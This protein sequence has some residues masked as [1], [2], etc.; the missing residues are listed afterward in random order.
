MRTNQ[1][2]VSMLELEYQN[3]RRH[4]QMRLK[5]RK[6]QI[7]ENY[8]Q[9]EKIDDEINL[10]YL[11][12]M[13]NSLKDIK[14]DEKLYEEIEDL[15][16]QRTELVIEKRIDITKLELEY[17]CNICKDT[18]IVEQRGKTN[19]CQCYTN[20]YNALAYENSNML[21]LTQKCNFE[22]FDI[23]VFDDEE[24]IGKYTQREFMNIMK[25]ISIR[26]I[27][28]FSDKDEKSMIFYG[29]TG[30]GKSY[31]CLCIAE[32][33]IKKR[34]SVIYES[35]IELFDKLASY[36]F[37]SGE[38]IDS[39]LS[40]FNSL[41]YNC[42]LLIIDD[43]GT[44]ITNSFVKQQLFNIINVRIINNKKTIIS[45]NLPLSEIQEKYEQRVYSRLSRYY[46]T[47]KFIGKD[48]R[49]FGQL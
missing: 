10:R 43:L 17:E 15:K 25:N 23:N 21:K 40:L 36:V 28:K 39:N 31:L 47:Y 30:L 26:F 42:D 46:D 49:I 3:K 38:K 1:E 41:V 27:D 7:Y 48:L 6:K 2:I 18:G 32:R 8:P 44:E 37:T 24:K 13:K 16:K 4:N 29:S 33:I 35:S 22:K 12:I 34:K 9:L 11:E 20:R 5:D 14:T 45:T 19:R